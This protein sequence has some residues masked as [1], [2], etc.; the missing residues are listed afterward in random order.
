M[1]GTTVVIID[2]INYVNR[3]GALDM[4]G[5]LCNCTCEVVCVPVLRGWVLMYPGDSWVF[6]G[7]KNPC[8]NDM[9]TEKSKDRL[10]GLKVIRS[11]YSLP[12]LKGIIALASHSPPGPIWQ[13]HD[14]ASEYPRSLVEIPKQQMGFP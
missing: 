14:A 6:K 12:L 11:R 8:L 5:I 1:A 2:S 7:K 4:P 9:K 13:I 3:E 10:D